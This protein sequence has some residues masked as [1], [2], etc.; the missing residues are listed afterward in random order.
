MPS[1]SIEPDSRR[2]KKPGQGGASN[3]RGDR[4]QI[5][6]RRHPIKQ[7]VPEEPAAPLYVCKSPDSGGLT[8]IGILTLS[9]SVL[10]AGALPWWP[11]SAS[12]RLRHHRPWHWLMDS[13]AVTD[14][15]DHVRGRHDPRGGEPRGA[16]ATRHTREP[17]GAYAARHTVAA[18]AGRDLLVAY[19]PQKVVPLNLKRP[20][21][22]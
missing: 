14:E 20:T 6:H 3:Q 7:A 4:R 21:L 19:R 10:L 22:P 18:G 2:R 16:F 15:K 11:Y 13:G 8:M 9:L 17:R 5:D 1:R 12:V